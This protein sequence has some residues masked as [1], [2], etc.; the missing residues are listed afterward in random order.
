VGLGLS[1]V[2]PELFRIAGNTRSL[3][4]SIGIA[5]VTGIGFLGFL[6]GPVLLGFLAKMSSLKLSFLALLIFVLISFFAAL[7]LKGKR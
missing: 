6:G 1:G 4:A 5:F 3:D 7:T 2:V